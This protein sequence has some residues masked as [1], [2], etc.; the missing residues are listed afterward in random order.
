MDAQTAATEI[1][2]KLNRAGY[3]AYFAGGWVR[4]HLMGH[5]SDD[6]DIA[7]DAPPEKILNLFPRTI[8]VGLAFGV[9]VVVVDSHQFEVAT[10]RRDV[11]YEGGRRPSQI[12]LSTPREDASRRDFTI[13]G[14][15][16]DPVEHVI[17]D[18]VQGAEDIK[19]GIIRT[20]GNADERFIEDRLR[21]IRAIRFAARFGFIIDPD[22]QEA[23]SANADTLFPAVAMERVW[24]E[25]TKMSKH[26]RFD[27]A[28]I[29]MHRLRL[30]PVIFPELEHVHLH[31]IKLYVASFKHFPKKAETI[32]YIMELF[33]QASIPETR[34]LCRYLH[35]SNA[36]AALAEFL[37]FVRQCIRSEHALGV[38][39]MCQWAHI[40]ANPASEVCIEV[41]AAKMEEKERKTFLAAHEQQRQILQRHIER[42]ATRKPLITA[43]LLQSEGIKPGKMMGILM[44]EA[45]RLAILHDL[46]NPQHIMELLRQSHA[47][48]HATSNDNEKKI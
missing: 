39:D 25:M 19:K 7:T 46:H 12:E 30:L 48:L 9:V 13:N 28:L 21:M 2:K 38:G 37:V 22:T 3:I 36:E 43:A 29:D 10:F 47:W 23:I 5:T 33:P 17:H 6:I 35:T 32:L 8:L 16:Y 45:E 20:I 11:N 18:F 15:F 34:E 14:M 26:P 41:I 27:S 4:D 1:V 31:D 24:Q 42:I 40:Y 44:K